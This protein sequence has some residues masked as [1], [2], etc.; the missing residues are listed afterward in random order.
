LDECFL[1]GVLSSNS[2]LYK[3]DLTRGGYMFRW[4]RLSFLAISVLVY[5]FSS[6]LTAQDIQLPKDFKWCVATSAH[7]IEGYN[8][9]SDWWFFE[10]EEGRIHNGDV[11]GPATDHWN[12]LEED[13]QLIKDLGAGVYR[14]SIEWAKIEPQPGVWDLTAVKHYREEI[15]LLKEAGIEPLITFHH[16]VF[17]QWVRELGGWEAKGIEDLFAKYVA[18]A[19]L[20]ITH[21]VNW[22]VTINEPMVHL[23][24]GYID[25]AHPPGE[26][27][28]LKDIDELIV[29]LLK[30]HAKAYHTLKEL[31][32]Q[33]GKE[34]SVSMS[35][36]LRAFRS[37][38]WI[39][40][41]DQIVAAYARK[42]WN[43]SVLGAVETGVLKMNMPGLLKIDRE[44][45]GLART[46]D[47]IGLNYYSRDL[48]HYSFKRGLIRTTRRRSETT[49]LGWEIYPKG[50]FRLL[51]R[52]YKKFPHQKIMITENGLADADDDQRIEFLKA[53]LSEVQKAINEGVPVMG[54]CYWSLLDNFEWA[55]GFDPRFGLVEVDYETFERTP[56]AS[57]YYLQEL[58]EQG[59]HHL[60]Q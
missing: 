29:G 59:L 7:Q 22:F 21:D 54:Y 46:Q 5:G 31:A 2:F 35:Y 28:E 13:T 12:R 44:I 58:I 3:L 38:T 17:P 19:Y 56:R 49:D 1:T 9:N 24:A 34:I 47:Y 55:E 6:T 30:S 15:R 39:N 32:A 27:R 16:F 52:V 10:H 43:W 57:Y 41:V 53:H 42:A 11:S 60:S 48:L 45:E 23:S 4:G 18:F 33:D 51:K 8:E 14:F 40:V 36:H 50:L 20:N 26:Q 37:K 25:G